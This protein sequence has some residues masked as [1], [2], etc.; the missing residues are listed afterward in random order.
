MVAGR[1]VAELSGTTHSL[2]SMLA[3]LARSRWLDHFRPRTRRKTSRTP[4][5]QLLPNRRSM[6]A[7]WGHGYAEALAHCH[8]SRARAAPGH[9]FRV[10]C[11]KWACSLIQ[12]NN[13]HSRARTRRSVCSRRAL[14]TQGPACVSRFVASSTVSAEGRRATCKQALPTRSC[15]VSRLLVLGGMADRRLGPQPR[16]ER[17]SN[18]R[19]SNW[20]VSSSP[21]TMRRRST[22]RS[23]RA[24]RTRPPRWSASVNSSGDGA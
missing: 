1:G 9:S 3:D 13:S 22:D 19:R 14:E 4:K 6:R 20:F 15:L 12:S 18:S 24:S 23:E 8:A 7:H 11:C 21:R 10:R 16:S 5:R 17:G 2:A